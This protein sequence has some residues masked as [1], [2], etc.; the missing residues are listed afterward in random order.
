MSVCVA[1]SREG[2]GNIL[3]MMWTAQHTAA[4]GPDGDSSKQPLPFETG[5]AFGRRNMTSH[6]CAVGVNAQKQL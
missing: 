5:S 2:K 1:T 4:A 6:L 3:D